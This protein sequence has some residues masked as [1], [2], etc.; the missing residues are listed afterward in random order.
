MMYT[1][2]VNGTGRGGQNL[3]EHEQQ[4]LFEARSEFARKHETAVI[5]AEAL[6]PTAAA[7]P[8]R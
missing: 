6:E 3:S 2:L 5:A 7:R 8:T 4:A 1:V